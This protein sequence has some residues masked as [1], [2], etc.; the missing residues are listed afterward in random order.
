[1]PAWPPSTP[2][3]HTGL[4]MLWSSLLLTALLSAGG[5]PGVRLSRSEAVALVLRQGPDLLE[6]RQ[7]VSR[8]EAEVQAA[9]ELPNPTL[10]VSYGPDDPRLFGTLEQRLPVFGQRSAGVRAARSGLGVARAE[11]QLQ[12]LR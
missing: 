6:A 9:G 12:T 10:G 8:A 3:P 4:Q 7:T 11:L 5:A 2:R 1:M